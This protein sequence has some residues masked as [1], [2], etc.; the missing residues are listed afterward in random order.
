MDPIS[1][2]FDNEGVFTITIDLM[3]T[4]D[5]VKVTLKVRKVPDLQNMRGNGHS[6]R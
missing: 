6:S 4:S 1:C 5:L 2:E 3:K